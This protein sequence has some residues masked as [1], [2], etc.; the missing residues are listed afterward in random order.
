M[1]PTVRYA[2]T[3]GLRIAYQVVGD[4]PA[5][6]VFMPGFVSHVELAW[7]DPHLAHFLRRLA[8]FRRL[9]VFDKRGTGLSDPITTRYTQAQRVD[10]IRAVMDA[11]G[12]EHATIFGVSE[13]GAMAILFA[14]TYPDRVD[15]LVL[16]S[17]VPRVLYDDDYTWGWTPQRLE[18][19]L[20][21]VVEL[22]GTGEGVEYANPTLEG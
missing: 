5:D 6:L 2:T 10:D 8:S 21:S 14:A 17:A 3:D 20:D 15:S 13:G 4:G 9:I 19:F 22:W 16:H 18:A 12:S 11:A 7:E 1:K